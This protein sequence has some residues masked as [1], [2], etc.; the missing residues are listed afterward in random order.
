MLQVGVLGHHG[1]GVR[2][3]RPRGR[4][5]EPRGGLDEVGGSRRTRSRS[6]IRT[7]SRRGRPACNQPASCPIAA[8]KRRSRQL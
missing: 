3:G 7:A 8:A 1:L 2:V 6:A 4:E 5:R